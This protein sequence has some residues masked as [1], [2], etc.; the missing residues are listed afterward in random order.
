MHK[1]TLVP[2][3]PIELHL[4]V[5]GGFTGGIKIRIQRPDGPKVLKRAVYSCHKI[6][7]I[8]LYETI[9]TP[10]CFICNMYVR[11]VEIQHDITLYLDINI[12]EAL[13]KSLKNIHGE[14]FYI[15]ADNTNILGP[16][17]QLVYNINC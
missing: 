13:Q 15:Y 10:N 12:D 5:F 16:W 1:C 17:L 2:L 8:L 4:S 6:F 3:I 14:Q 7:H 11:E 9:S